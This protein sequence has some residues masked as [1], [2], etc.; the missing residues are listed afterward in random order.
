MDVPF[1]DFV[2]N[3]GVGVPLI[4]IARAQSAS[5][6]AATALSFDTVATV[7]GGRTPTPATP[8]SH[9]MPDRCG[10]WTTSVRPLRNVRQPTTPRTPTIAP[11][12]ADRTGTAR[13]PRPASVASREPISNAGGRLFNV[14]QRAANGARP[15]RALS[16]RTRSSAV[17]HAV[18][19]TAI[20]RAERTDEQDQPVRVEAD[21]EVE[22]A[23]ERDGEPRREEH[24][25]RDAGDRTD[26]RGDGRRDDERAAG[27]APIGAE[28]APRRQVRA[29][30]RDRAH[31]R[32]ADE[33][34]G[35]DEH[36][37]REEQ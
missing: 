3:V 7:S 26:N 22:L 21:V 1:T 17:T 20:D 34:A 6:A 5:Y 30:G 25:D 16:R 9:T 10:S 33:R 27:D 2:P 36:R 29:A 11:I 37:E 8:A 14:V 12:S 18:K 35:T 32:L 13:R 15:V 31:E 28:G 23:H 24:R 4:L 19:T